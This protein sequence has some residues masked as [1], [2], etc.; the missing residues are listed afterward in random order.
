MIKLRSVA[1]LA[2]HKEIFVN[3]FDC[4]ETL[5]GYQLEFILKWIVFS[6]YDIKMKCYSD[7]WLTRSLSYLQQFVYMQKHKTVQQLFAQLGTYKL[8]NKKDILKYLQTT[9]FNKAYFNSWADYLKLR[10]KKAHKHL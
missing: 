8:P 9:D 2:K 3:A 7:T 1:E 10:K 6:M 5:I 4:S